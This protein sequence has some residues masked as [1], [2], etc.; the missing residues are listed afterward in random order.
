MSKVTLNQFNNILAI[1]SLLSSSKGIIENDPNYI[2]DKFEKY[3]GDVSMIKD[4][5]SHLSGLH[6]V[7][8]REVIDPYHEKWENIIESTIVRSDKIRMVIDDYEPV[9]P[10]SEETAKGLSLMF[11]LYIKHKANGA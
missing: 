9:K 1:I 11:D 5:C 6:P 7:L 2:I 3:I 10:M 8:R 4:D